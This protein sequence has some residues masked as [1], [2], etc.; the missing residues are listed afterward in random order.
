DKSDDFVIVGYTAPR[1]SRPY[2]GALH[3]GIYRGGELHYAGSVGTGFTD[4]QLREIKA[5]L[6]PQIRKTAPVKTPP[7]GKGHTWI[8]PVFVVE[9]RFKE[10]TDEP[11]LRHP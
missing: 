11:L 2:F 7:P 3:V 1:G 8:E 9:V 6:D 4:K 5:Q 10:W